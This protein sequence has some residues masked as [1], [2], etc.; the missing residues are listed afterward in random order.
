[1]EINFGFNLLLEYQKFNGFNLESASTSG[2]IKFPRPPT[3]RFAP[4]PHWGL[5]PQT[6]LKPR[7]FGTRRIIDLLGQPPSS[8]NTIHTLCNINIFQEAQVCFK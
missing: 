3:R 2:E 1:M 5:R 4:G 6:P 7:A 8:N